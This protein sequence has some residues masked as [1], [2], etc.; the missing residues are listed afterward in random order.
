MEILEIRPPMAGDLD[1]ND[2]LSIS[3]V[4]YVL[5]DYN[6]PMGVATYARSVERLKAL[7]P[8]EEELKKLIDNSNREEE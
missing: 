1:I 2:F 6:R 5:Q 8:P 4:E 3:F 7:L